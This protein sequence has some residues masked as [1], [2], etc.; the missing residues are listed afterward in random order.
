M[1]FI[2]GYLLGLGSGGGSKVIRPI[3]I[4]E[5]GKYEAPEGV[6]GFNPVNVNVNGGG[7]GGSSVFNDVV[8]LPAFATFSFGE[9]KIEYKFKVN[10]PEQS[11][12]VIISSL[13][14][15]VI[16]WDAEY[17]YKSS[18]FSWVDCMIIGLVSKNGNPMYYYKS[19]FTRGSVGYSKKDDTLYPYTIEWHENFN[20]TSAKIPSNNKN[21]LDFDISWK[22]NQ[23]KFNEFGEKI[24]ESS[25][26]YTDWTALNI[27]T[28]SS[29]GG[30]E[31]TIITN[32][33]AKQ[34]GIVLSEFTAEIYK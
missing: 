13:S 28:G 7:G 29:L 9:Y 4:T 6:D 30:N 16:N 20:C 21:G 2:A 23:I 3:T 19:L 1:S 10:V 15:A 11:P 22:A 24:S 25:W 34:F 31:D 12:N 14:G 8:D 5:N 26:T 27:N 17:G 33:S 18:G 32:L